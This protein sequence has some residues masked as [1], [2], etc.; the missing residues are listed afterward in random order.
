MV[1]FKGLKTE[2][3]KFNGTDL[4]VSIVGKLNGVFGLDN[5]RIMEFTGNRS[6]GLQICNLNNLLNEGNPISLVINEEDVLEYEVLECDGNEEVTVK[7]SNNE[8]VII[9]NC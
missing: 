2:L 8:S 9:V 5:C 6:K 7:L 4:T 1:N 3:Q